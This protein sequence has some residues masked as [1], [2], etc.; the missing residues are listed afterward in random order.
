MDAVA[1]TRLI[2]GQATSPLAGAPP[3]PG[4][5]VGVGRPPNS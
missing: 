4:G 1:V 5:Q 3:C 2:A